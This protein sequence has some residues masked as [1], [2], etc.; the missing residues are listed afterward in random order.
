MP[1][2]DWCLFSFGNRRDL[3]HQY[4]TLLNNEGIS[5][6]Q[7]RV[8]KQLQSIWCAALTDGRNIVFNN[9][10][11]LQ[12]TKPNAVISKYFI[13]MTLLSPSRWYSQ[14][15]V[16]CVLILLFSRIVVKFDFQHSVSF[17]LQTGA[18]VRDN[19]FPSALSSI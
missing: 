9:S 12:F 13:F 3:F 4:S 15:I 16:N 18:M 10:I 2:T 5:L 8:K 11:V 17:V 1:L 6:T 19:Y 14:E 7:S